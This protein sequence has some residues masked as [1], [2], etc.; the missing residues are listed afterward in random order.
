[1]KQYTI[2]FSAGYTDD[3]ESL[4]KELR[5]DVLL[6]DDKGNYYDI[7][8]LTINRIKGE[9]DKDKVCY[10]EENMVIL[11][12][13][14]KDNILMS[15]REL[16]QWAFSKR[17]SPLSHEQVEKYYYPKDNWMLFTVEIDEPM[18]NDM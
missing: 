15:I 1:M 10:L 2:I 11:H 17:W 3:I 4:M 18:V 9:F 5:G 16:H 14:T 7:N 6:L 12:E 8:F 13:V